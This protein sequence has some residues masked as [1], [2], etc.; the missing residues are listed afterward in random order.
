MLGAYRGAERNRLR[1]DW[2][3]LGGS[4][5]ADLLGELPTLRERSRDLNR[6]DA[7]AAAI[8]NTV[9]VNT[10]GTGI[11]PQCR[12][13][14]E[15]LGLT[16][17]AARTFERAAERAWRSWCPLADA[18]NRVDF[19][20][21]QGLVQRQIL[22]NGEVFILPLML[23]Q[24]KWRPVKLA[25]EVIEADRVMTPPGK[26]GDPTMRDGIELGARGE[27]VAYWVRKRHPGDVLLGGSN[28]MGASIQDFVRY[29]AMNA[30][31]RRN[32]FHL[33]WVKR[34]GQT[35]GE[36]FFS[37]VLTAFKDLGDFLE[38]YLVAARIEACATA[39]IEKTNPYGAVSSLTQTDGAGKRV[40]EF[41][42]GSIF[43]GQEGEKITFFSPQRASGVFEPFV[44]AMLRSIGAALGLPLE[45]VLKDFSRTNYSSARAALLEARRFFQGY[46]Q[47]LAT[48]L[49]QP[50]WEMVL[51][52]AWLRELLP[53]INLFGEQRDQWMKARWLAPGWGWVD[54]TKEAEASKLAMDNYV[55][56]LAEECASRGVDYEDNLR[57]IAA[58]RKLMEELNLPTPAPSAPGAQGAAPAP[59]ADEETTYA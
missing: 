7:H 41:E 57:Q 51:E 38:A 42:P 48:R 26:S 27:P 54:P 9:V 52:E 22:E 45:L 28:T 10:V 46:Q 23:K 1:K 24:D 55:S 58:E 21:L 47:W 44:L 12:L 19:Y 4:P 29:P 13:D 35:R 30:A 53:S 15:G 3:P 8:T 36:P 49:C 17:A 33:Y 40:Q 32:V 2:S 39:F 50:V 11:K 14:R 43:Y 6:N 56:T 37:P 25:L 18:Q 34:P 20:E 59:A 5:D 31:G 16:E